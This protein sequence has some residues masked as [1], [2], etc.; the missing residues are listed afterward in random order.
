[1]FAD[2]NRSAAYFRYRHISIITWAASQTPFQSLPLNA[3][4][5]AAVELHELVVV[6][7]ERA[8]AILTARL[9]NQGGR[10]RGSLTDR[11]IAATAIR[12]GAALATTDP[13]DFRRF[14]PAGL[15]LAA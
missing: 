1:M 10:R 11:M 9:F 14:E 5:G 3:P 2:A 12:T 6:G 8:D 7:G 13:A 4:A 15:K